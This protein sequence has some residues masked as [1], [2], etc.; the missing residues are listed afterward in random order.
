M[1]NERTIHWSRWFNPPTVSSAS[2]AMYAIW[3]GVAML[4]VAVP[5]AADLTNYALE[6]TSGDAVV[7]PDSASLDITGPITIEAWVRPSALIST[8]SFNFIVSKNMGGTGYA[9]LDWGPAS[10]ES[11]RF[12]AN[13]KSIDLSVQGTTPLQIDVWTHVAGVWDAGIGMLYIDGVLNNTRPNPNPPLSN[14]LPLYIGGSPFGAGTSWEGE[15]DEVRIWN[16][17]RTAQEIYDNKNWILTG[18]ESGLVAY[19]HFDEGTDLTTADATGHG[20]I[21]SLDTPNWV[22][23]TA[24]VS[25]VPIPGGMLTRLV[26]Y[27]MDEVDY[28]NIAPEL[29]GSLLAKIDAALAAIDRGNPND[30]KV[31]MNNLKALIN[32]VEAQIDKKITPDAAAEIIQRVNAIIAA[33]SG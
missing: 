19:W 3:V 24:P 7:V 2:W 10:S 14:D 29:E 31:A 30:A 25:L 11:Y 13:N 18:T 20:N 22:P 15:I 12:E 28:G 33:L 9:L 27:I 4:F 16:V 26:L 17:A 5:V 6:F 23:S 21:G 8:S 1:K 32:H